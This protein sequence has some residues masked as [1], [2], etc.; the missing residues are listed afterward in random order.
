MVGGQSRDR[1]A[2]LIYAFTRWQWYQRKSS[3]NFSV[4]QNS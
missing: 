2:Y 4:A 1:L 3:A